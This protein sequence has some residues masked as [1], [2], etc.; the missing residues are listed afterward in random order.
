LAEA[1]RMPLVAHLEELRRRLLW[2][3]IAVAAGAVV[4]WI[5]YP[6]I[7]DFLLEPY[8][9]IRDDLGDQTV[10][11]SGCELLVTDPLEPFAVRMTVAGYGGV[12]IAMPVL[13][14][15]AWRF[16]A[17]ALYARE[18]RWAI[19]FVFCGLVL[20]GGGCVLAFWSIPRALDFLVSIGGPDLVSVFSPARYLGF[21]V[22]MTLAFGI[23]FEFPLV[24]IFLQLTGIVTPET[25]RRARRYA[26]V[27]I[28]ALV[29]LLTPSGDPFTLLVLS[30]PM[31]FFY[32]GAI[33]F[34][35]LYRR[36]RR[37]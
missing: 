25:L 11:G 32:E 2:S 20:F 10:F 9:Q 17:P 7:L 27:G 15:Q 34:G 6:W 18:R 13:L 28:V 23:G 36:R 5:F 29:A 8:C 31:L 21:V 19:P 33:L 22:K 12:G 30:V 3:T 26:V 35:V 1:E 4:C 14:W 37:E 16:T 24:L